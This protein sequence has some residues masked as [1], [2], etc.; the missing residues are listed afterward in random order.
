M[1]VLLMG[2]FMKY[3][4]EIGSDATILSRDGVSDYRRGLDW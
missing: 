3:T 2:E 1:L 4:V